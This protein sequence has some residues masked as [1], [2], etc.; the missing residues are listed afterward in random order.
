[1]ENA[2]TVPNKDHLKPEEIGTEVVHE[3]AR[4]MLARLGQNVEGTRV[5]FDREFVMEQLKLAPS[6]VTVRGR[7]AAR[8][9]A[10]SSPNANGFTT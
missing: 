6:H 9:R 8:A 7:N 4:E 3:P 1:M 5:C 10:I 2:A